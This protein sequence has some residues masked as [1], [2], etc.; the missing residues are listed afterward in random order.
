MPIE[1]HK[2]HGNGSGSSGRGPNFKVTESLTKGAFEGDTDGLIL[3]FFVIASRS[4]ASDFLLRDLDSGGSVMS[5]ISSLTKFFLGGDVVAGVE[6]SP[7]RDALR[8]SSR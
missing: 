4:F 7:S 5:I 1:T 6:V 2:Q 8:S 3:T